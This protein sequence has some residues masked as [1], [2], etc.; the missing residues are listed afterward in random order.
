MYSVTVPFGAGRPGCGPFGFAR[1]TTPLPLATSRRRPSGVTRTDV[2]YHP[3]GMKPSDRLR[4]RR[5]T[6]KTA[7][8]LRFAFAT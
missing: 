3:A 5:A 8:T 2:G 6:S 1:A 7:T 4:P